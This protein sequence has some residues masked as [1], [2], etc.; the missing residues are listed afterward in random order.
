LGGLGG[1]YAGGGNGVK[2]GG[3]G[4]GSGS[5]SELRLK[6]VKIPNEEVCEAAAASTETAMA[7]E[8]TWKAFRGRA[9][10]Y[11]AGQERYVQ[12]S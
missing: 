8:Q 1:G 11:G 12:P 10:V 6:R 9:L 5:L 4:G 7:A 3:G 2:E